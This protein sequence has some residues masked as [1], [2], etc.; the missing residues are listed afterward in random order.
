MTSHPK[1]SDALTQNEPAL[2][3]EATIALAR[4]LA[5][6]LDLHTRLTV[7]GALCTLSDV[8]PPYPPHPA[9]VAPLDPEEGLTRAFEALTQ[10][11]GQALPLPQ[12][13]RLTLVARDLHDLLTTLATP[14]TA[15][16]SPTEPTSA[17]ES[18]SPDGQAQP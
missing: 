18:P 3:A 15:T 2:I 6:D 13:V 14:A 16:T 4:V 7:A 8:H 5:G 12:L 17:T 10:H 1:T 9:D 11:A